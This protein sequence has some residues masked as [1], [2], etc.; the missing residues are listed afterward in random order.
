[1]QYQFELDC[2]VS[3]MVIEQGFGQLNLR[4]LARQL[5][6]RLIGIEIRIR[7]GEVEGGC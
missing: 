3:D 1:M 2:F 4:E 6:S 5:V 7:Y